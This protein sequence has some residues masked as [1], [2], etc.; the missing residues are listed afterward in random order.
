MA[1]G[2]LYDEERE[3]ELLDEARDDARRAPRRDRRDHITG[4]RLIEEDIHET[5][6]EFIYRETR[7]RPMIMPVVVEV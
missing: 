3:Q 7:Q 4:Q 5:L 6:A 2:F 1:R